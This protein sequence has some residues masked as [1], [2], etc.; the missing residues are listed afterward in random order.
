MW[1]VAY[2]TFRE[3]V[4]NKILYGIAFFAVAFVGLAVLLS[5]LSLG[6]TARFVRDL[7]LSGTEIFGLVLVLFVGSQLLFKEVDGK[8]VYLI[9]TKPIPRRSFVLGKFLGF[10]LVLALVMALQSAAF[11]ATLWFYGEAPSAGV[12][13]A[14][15]SSYAKL[16]VTFAFLLLFSSFSSSFVAILAA[17]LLYFAAHGVAGILDLALSPKTRSAGL[18]IVGKILYAVLPNFE[19]L[20]LKANLDVPNAPVHSVFG[21]SFP[22]VLAWANLAYAGVYGSALLAL[23]C[24]AFSRKEFAK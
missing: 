16:L 6:D 15:L 11:V 3:L 12:A 1:N 9:L 5:T 14:I 8:T 13:L 24:V 19:A 7:G 21:V 22:Y 17:L 10:A 2:N 20:N 4:R 23:A 18:E